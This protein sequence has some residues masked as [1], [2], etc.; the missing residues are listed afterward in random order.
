MKQHRFILQNIRT[1]WGHPTSTQIQMR[2]K[3]RNSLQNWCHFGQSKLSRSRTVMG[4]HNS[5]HC[6]SRAQVQ[7]QINTGMRSCLCGQGQ[8]PLRSSL[9]VCLITLRQAFSLKPCGLQGKFEFMLGYG[10]STSSG[11][12]STR[13]KR[14]LVNSPTK[15]GL[16]TASQTDASSKKGIQYW[17]DSN[18]DFGK[19]TQ[20]LAWK[21]K[22]R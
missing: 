5:L 10:R 3:V 11:L 18:C 21:R 1:C 9:S 14:L 8:S 7:N 4:I 20:H 16:N 19:R 22:R 2:I 6:G 13:L 17:S 12:S 15:I